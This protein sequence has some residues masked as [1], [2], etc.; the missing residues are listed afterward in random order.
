MVAINFQERFVP[1]ILNG[2]K[3]TT[4]HKTNRFKVGD[5]LQL[6]TGQRTKQ[7]R[8][9]ADAVV[10]DVSP[11]TIYH[12]RIIINGEYA[13]TEDVAHADGFESWKEMYKWFLKTHRACFFDGWIVTFEL[14]KPDAL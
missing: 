14:E 7:C 2:T 1:L 10:L 8:K 9:I 6:Y 5:K 3:T 4:I 11:V 12:D 13:R